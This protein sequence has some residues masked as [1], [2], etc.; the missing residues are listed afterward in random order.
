MV[1]APFFYITRKKDILKK[2]VREL[3]G[4]L[5]NYVIKNENT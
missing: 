2:A 3:D 1:D 5:E 4:F